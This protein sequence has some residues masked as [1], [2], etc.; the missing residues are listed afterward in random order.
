MSSMQFKVAALFE[1]SAPFVEDPFGQGMKFYVL[2]GD[3][4]Q[5]TSR[6]MKRLR[7]IG[8]KG[9][10]DAQDTLKIL[11]DKGIVDEGGQV[12]D[13]K[14]AE[15]PIK[16]ILGEGSD[17]DILSLVNYQ[18]NESVESA[19][20][21]VS[22]WEGVL[23]AKGEPVEFNRENL[24]GL[25]KDQTVVPEGNPFA[26]RTIGEAFIATITEY[27]ETLA[28][29]RAAAHAVESEAGEF[30]GPGGDGTLPPAVVSE[31]TI[32]DSLPSS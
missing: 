30:S 17:I 26:L 22:K 14:A 25:L 11:E 7:A 29:K 12:V 28:E 6:R 10:R 21:R 5:V 16:D 8:K 13:A 18:L 15:A 24:E 19:I 2:P 1:E 31:A 27:S 3:H 20:D 4:P 9:M 23:D 32:A